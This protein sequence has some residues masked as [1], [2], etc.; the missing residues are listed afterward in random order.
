MLSPME[1]AGRLRAAGFKVTPQRL[2]VYNMLSHTKVHPNADTIYKEL[3]P[4]YP[5]MSLATVYKAL[6]ILC[7]LGLAQEL[8]VGED[9]F[10]YDADTSHHPHVRCTKCLRVD[11][12]P[13]PRRK[14]YT[15]KSRV[16]PVM[17]LPTIRS[18]SSA[19]ARNARKSSSICMPCIEQMMHP[20][21]KERRFQE[22]GNAFLL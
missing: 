14:V 3:Q 4:L 12:V 20:S 6:S 19:F 7:D 22:N 8:N 17:H 2:A 10:R 13:A 1:L 21:I 18:I 5:T 16:R 15:R 11:D 9:A